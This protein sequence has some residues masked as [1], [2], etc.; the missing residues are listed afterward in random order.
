MNHSLNLKEVSWLAV[1][2]VVYL[3]LSI[4]ASS[5]VYSSSHSMFHIMTCHPVPL[6]ES[7]HYYSCELGPFEEQ[8]ARENCKHA[9]AGTKN[10]HTL[11][12]KQ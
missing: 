9:H 6:K 4:L 5:R 12:T 10:K 1:L 7:T 2:V 3:E 11:I 8:M